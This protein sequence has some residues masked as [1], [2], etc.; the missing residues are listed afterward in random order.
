MMMKTVTKRLPSKIRDVLTMTAAIQQAPPDH[1]GGYELESD[2]VEVTASTYDEAM[3]QVLGRVPEGWRLLS[4][5]V[6]RG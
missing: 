1:R 4:V 3:A 6:D 5:R 2:Q